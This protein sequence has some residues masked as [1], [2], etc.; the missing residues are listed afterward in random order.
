MSNILFISNGH[1]E[2]LISSNIIKTFKK[3][4]K[5]K[6][7]FALPMVGKGDILRG[8]KKINI[9]GPQKEMASGGFIKRIG[10]LFTDILAGLLSLHFRQI[11]NA[12]KHKY[13]LVVC[14]GD[15]FPFILSFFFLKYKNIVLVS[16]A[17]SDLF[18][19][20]FLI[21]RLF[22]KLAKAKVL[23]R[24]QITADNL[25]A[26][27]VDAK[28]LGN[29]MMDDLKVRS[30]INSD[31]KKDLTLG[32]LPGSRKEAYKNYTLIK[33]VLLRLPTSWNILVAVPS[34]LDRSNFLI[35]EKM[36]SIQIVGFED[37][38]NSAD[39]VIGL[40]GTANEQVIGVGLPLFTF[41]GFGTQTTR[42][43]F[44]DQQKLLGG[45]PVYVDSQDSDIIAK[46]IKKSMSDLEFI[47]TGLEYGPKI[48]GSSGAA[49]KISKELKCILES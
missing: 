46:T 49:N 29:V 7:V 20:H 11:R 43:R 16:T 4:F 13:D 2:D 6:E 10:L 3:N 40:A 21:E 19:K 35:S 28:Y 33:K 34:N 48:M 41:P 18:E 14:V 5:K 45:L 42:R 37:M 27:G 15:F 1:G 23:T 32:V 47:K 17:K 36:N 24:D 22:I 30:R 25:L 26:R 8:D 39:A 9:I 44:L 38:L 31:N 12:S